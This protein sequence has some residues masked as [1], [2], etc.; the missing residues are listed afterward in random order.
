M[1]PQDWSKLV[2]LTSN[3]MN[4]S[5]C[6]TNKTPYIIKG[7]ANGDGLI[8]QKLTDPPPCG[9]LMPTIGNPMPMAPADVECFRK[10]ATHLAN[11]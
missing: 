6:G 7:S 11:Q 5:A 2:G 1:Q 9:Q 3:G 8:M 4:A 10:W